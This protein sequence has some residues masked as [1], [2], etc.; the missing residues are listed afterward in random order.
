MKK[1][2]RETTE[3]AA[4]HLS[5]A[6]A[7]TALVTAFA[8]IL[9]TLAQVGIRAAEL[10]G[11]ALL[12]YTTPNHWVGDVH[13]YYENGT[14]HLIYVYDPGEWRVGH[15]QSRDLLH[16]EEREMAH[17]PAP[18]VPEVLPNYYVLQIIPDTIHGG[19]RT[20]YPYY[21][22]RASRSR[23]LVTWRYADPQLVVPSLPGYGRMADPYPFW[24]EDRHE[25]WMVVTL[26]KDGLPL[27]RA[28]AFG[29][30]TSAD[31]EHWTWRGELYS[32]GNI[33]EPELPLMF[34]MGQRWY[35]LGFPNDGKSLGEPI[36]RV[37]SSCDGPWTVPTPDKLDGKHFCAGRTSFDGTRRLLFGW[38]PKSILPSGSQYWGGHFALPRELYALPDG[39][40][41][42]R[43]EPSVAK[44]IRGET[45]FPK[46]GVALM[47]QAGQWTIAGNA[48]SATQSGQRHSVRIQPAPGS[49]DLTLNVLLRDKCD[50]AGIELDRKA[51]GNGFEV[52]IDRKEKHLA[53]L[54]R[55]GTVC[56]AQ[57]ID[58][59][60][61]CKVQLRVLV[62]G[63]IVEAFLADRYALAARLPAS[64]RGETVEL[65]AQGPADFD[66]IDLCRLLALDEIKSSAPR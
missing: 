32:P 43:L 11:T 61:D 18:L 45:C 15:L 59:L 40:L 13:P 7:R 27:D 4:Q 65:F 39:R 48:A 49:I 9:L 51:N 35:L 26:R 36:Y 20:F 41:A 1:H 62:D 8:T 55:D 2:Q 63:D 12:H 46:T 22:I 19:Y 42:V 52:V 50:R 31:L 28:G 64:V 34:K 6:R 30:A 38:I 56:A 10:P 21:G 25:Y 57:A 58:D 17:T 54:N 53:V 16:W 47:P 44:R 5:N 33:G 29:Y 60:N 66:N 37:S 23:D 3:L 14:Y 24:N